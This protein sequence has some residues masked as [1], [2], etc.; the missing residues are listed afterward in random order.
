ME[1]F[2]KPLKIL[3]LTTTYPTE[4]TSSTGFF[5]TNITKGL[6]KHNA[7]VT[8]QTLSHSHSYKKYTDK[9]N[10][11]V[12]QIPYSFFLKPLMKDGGLVN[13]LKKNPLTFIQ[14]IEYFITQFL[15]LAQ[16]GSK[17]DIVHGHWI[18]TGGL[19]ACLTKPF[20]KKPVVITAHGAE[21]YMKLNPIYK[22]IFSF[23]YKTA[24]KLIFVSNHLV[25]RAK[26]QGVEPPKEKVHII[27]NCVDTDKFKPAI[28]PKENKFTFV[29]LGR[30]SQEKRVIDIVEAVNIIPDDVKEKM[31][32]WVI[33]HGPEKETIQNRIKELGLEKQFEMFDYIENNK[34]PG[35]LSR[36]HAYVKLT[37][38]EGFATTNVE[39]QA[40]GLPAIS[41]KGSG[42]EEIFVEGYN[43]F[44]FDAMDVKELA[45]RMIYM[46]ENPEIVSQMSENAR[47]T[48]VNR[49]SLN[50]IGK[51]YSNMYRDLKNQFKIAKSKPSVF[52]TIAD[53]S[54]V[55]V[56]P[57]FI[58]YLLLIIIDEIF[59]QLISVQFNLDFV[60]LIL[61]VVFSL[62][63]L[64]HRS[65]KT[66][67]PNESSS[68]LEK[69]ILF[70][71]IS[72][73]SIYMYTVIGV[74]GIPGIVATIL[75]T[76]LLI[77]FIFLT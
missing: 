34:V 37:V 69:A 76:I 39:S 4:D 52:N 23:C 71:V 67:K 16:N 5:L 62:Y 10:N 73:I 50:I 9:Y 21:F 51:E 29:V 3:F 64:F 77:T 42:N 20:H 25:N 63:V 54:A 44:L 40:S 2:I 13:S 60:F 72:I 66:K 22:M 59:P 35:Y 56:Y 49:F 55:I 53:L 27:Y 61:A 15:H 74:Y 31:K 19:L 32:V 65:F 33:G 14:I 48:A 68:F 75:F 57:L 46:V 41:T 6:E 8:I 70:I 45:V 43:A 58:L 47:R 18:I 28:E 24:D 30:L 1:N 11:D 26:E 12:I 7:K 36:A 38:Q 17:F